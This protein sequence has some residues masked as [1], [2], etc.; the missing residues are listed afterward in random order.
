MRKT[1]NGDRHRRTRRFDIFSLIVG[2]RTHSAV[3]R[4]GH[5]IIADF[6]RTVL[7]DYRR[8]RTLTLIQTRF[9]HVTSC[10]AVGI[11]FKLHILGLEQ[12]IFQQSIYALVLFG[13]NGYHRHI[14]AP[15]F[16]NQLVFGKLLLDPVDIGAL[17]IYFVYR[18]DDG[19]ICF[20]RVFDRFYRLRHHTVVRR[21]NKYGNIGYRRAA[22]AHFGK[23]F[24]SRRIQES[25]LFA[26][27]IDGIRAYM[28]SYSSCFA[29][30][31]GSFADSVQKRSFTVVYVSHN[32]DY[33][34]TLDKAFFGIGFGMKLEQLLFF[35]FLEF[36]FDIYAQSIR[37]KLHGGK[38]DDGIYRCHYS[39]FHKLFYNFLRGL[40]YL[41]G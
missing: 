31:Y 37:N 19:N 11:G 10:A 7:N 39:Q 23:R 34:R 36:K 5:N 6:K 32:G 33:G 2:K 26:V 40:T 17:L 21:N 30:D 41:F 9:D 20:L 13:G 16:A 15:F 29:A 27:E 8:N 4:A 22:S 38:I 12:N 24:M 3:S 18:N 14:A 28:L 25:Y 35:G 1:V